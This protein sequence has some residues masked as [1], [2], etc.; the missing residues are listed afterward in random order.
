MADLKDSIREYWGKNPNAASIGGS[1]PRDSREFYEKVA[2]HR[3]RT[4][5]SIHEMAEFDRWAG[6]FVLEVGCGMGTDLRQ[7]AGSGAQVVGIDLTW[8]GVQM[9]QIAFGLF[10]VRGDF[11]VADA[12]M[13]PFREESF[14]LVY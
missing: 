5:P 7:F 4:E 13:L 9:A 1:R 2:E 14:D 3:Y 12:E 6:K 10:G 11:V 8:Q